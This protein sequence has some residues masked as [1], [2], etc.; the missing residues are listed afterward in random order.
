[1]LEFSN[2]INL[3]MQNLSF[4]RIILGTRVLVTG[5]AGLLGSHLAD[6]L[7][8]EG[9]E[10]IGVDNL[11]GGYK[12]NIPSKVKFTHGDTSNLNLML[13]L[14]KDV[15]VVFH[16]ACTAYE[17]LSVFSPSIISQNTFGNSIPVFSAAIANKVRRIVYC[18]SMARY[19][20]QETIPFNESMIPMPQDPYGISK[21]A[22]ENVLKH[23]SD[24]HGIEWSI[25]V[26]HNIIG[27]RQKYDDPFRNVAS[28]MINLLLQGKSPYIYGNGEQI[29][30]FSFIQD[31]V[32]PLSLMGFSQH[33]KNEI[34][35]IGPDENPITI[36]QLFLT[37]SKLLNTDLS[38]IYVP[39]R[40]KEVKF[41]TCS[42][43]KARTKLSYS[44]ETSLD[45][46]LLSMIDWIKFRGPRVFDYRLP[47]EIMNKFT[48]KTWVE[49]LF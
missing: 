21:V 32:K 38:P 39:E 10:V 46:G 49:R 24:V 45:D 19:G 30:C 8:T 33:A 1:M 13:S 44:T 15:D 41:A 3:L 4:E 42:A 9:H 35:N 22:S 26:P 14:T 20:H 28:I 40:P 31:V 5:V 25:A 27:P 16:A 43:N 29:R 17:G 47:I 2:E 7:L 48:P 12:D 6:S 18:S 23:L 11:I 37:V 34:I 36:N